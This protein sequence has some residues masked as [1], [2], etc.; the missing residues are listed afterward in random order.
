[1]KLDK[2]TTRRIILIITFAI[3]LLVV[4]MNLDSVGMG[5]K[6]I[7]NLFLPFFLGAAIAFIFNVPMRFIERRLFHKLEAKVKPKHEKKVFL[8]KRIIAYLITL[9]IV[10]GIIVLI[11]LVV[12]PEIADTVAMLTTQIPLAIKEIEAFAADINKEAPYL[13]EWLASA[14]FDWTALGEKASGLLADAPTMVINYGVDLISSVAGAIF[15]G[16]IAF[17]FSIYL[18]LQQ[19][20]LKRHFGMAARAIFP[21]RVA[22]EGIRIVRLS[23]KTFANF[24][25][26]QCLEACILGVICFIGMSIFRLPLAMMASVIVGVCSLIPIF[27]AFIGCAI[28]MA[29][30]AIVNPIQALIFLALIIVIQQL[31]GNLIYP[32][33]VGTAIGLPSIWVLVAVTI[34]A[35]M[36]GIVGMIIFIPLCSVLYALFREFVYKRLKE[37]KSAVEVVKERTK[38]D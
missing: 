18:L 28:G 22:N 25:A 32:H 34:G 10:A 12:V 2:K 30:I 13:E 17:A 8:L 1:M 16:V 4:L 5:I 19:E 37:K 24:F 15:N 11:V 35:K 38:E 3:V 29:L 26:G 23:Y 9:G 21:T 31:E 7:G 20:N 14:G 6:W 36:F 33:V 27:G